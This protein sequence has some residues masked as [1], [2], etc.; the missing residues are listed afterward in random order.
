MSDNSSKRSPVETFFRMS[1][2]VFAGL[3]LLQLSLAVLAEIWPWIVGIALAAEA[4]T[5]LVWWLRHQNTW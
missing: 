1:L 5:A 4:T 3:V 2:Y